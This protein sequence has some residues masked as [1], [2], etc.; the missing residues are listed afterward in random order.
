MPKMIIKVGGER[1][2]FG[3]AAKAP[4]ILEIEVDLARPDKVYTVTIANRPVDISFSAP[5]STTEEDRQRAC[6]L[7]LTRGGGC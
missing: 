6:A 3:T 7:P 2:G 5:Q 1:G 4:D